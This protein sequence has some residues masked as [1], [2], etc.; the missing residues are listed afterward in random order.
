MREI[1]TIKIIEDGGYAFWGTYRG[2]VVF[3]HVS[4]LSNT[5][6]IPEAAVPKAGETIR[7]V[8]FKEILGGEELPADVSKGG[9]YPVRYAA[10]VA[11]LDIY[12]HR[13]DDHRGD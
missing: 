8:I 13:T 7:A 2:D 9:K 5:K 1:A 11:Q 10:S 4:E 12:V 6:P 3:I